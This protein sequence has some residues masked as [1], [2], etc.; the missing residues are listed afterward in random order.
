[1]EL[2]EHIARLPQEKYT[3]DETFQ[4]CY[5]V[6]I[7]MKPGNKLNVFID[8]DSGIDFEKCRRLSRYLESFIDANGWLGEKYTLE[9]SSPGLN[10]PLKFLRQYQKNIGRTLAVTLNDKTQHAGVLKSVTED[11]IVIT[12]T[13]IERE[14][15][16]KKEV[17]IET[18]IKLETIE[19]AIVKPA[20]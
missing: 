18:L 5:T 20:F 7:E 4:D 3:S 2:T 14:G 13:A 6:E 17:E 11:S 12:H 16:K 15:K 8:A 19:K 10:R 1:M 9:V